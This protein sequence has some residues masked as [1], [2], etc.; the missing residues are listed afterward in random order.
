MMLSAVIV[1]MLFV[2]AGFVLA[3]TEDYG[4]SPSVIFVAGASYLL[5]LGI[6]MLFRS[7]R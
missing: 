1:C 3:Y 2:G 4:I 5:A 7:C 6:R